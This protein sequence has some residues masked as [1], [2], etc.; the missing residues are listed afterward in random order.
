MSV[1]GEVRATRSGLTGLG[2]ENLIFNAMDSS[3]GA[4]KN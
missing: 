1:K 4:T 3:E 2:S